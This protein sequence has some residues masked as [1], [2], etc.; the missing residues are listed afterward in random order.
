MAGEARE[1]T[2]TRARRCRD[3]RGVPALARRVF[4][5]R[6]HGALWWAVLGLLSAAGTKSCGSSG[7]FGSPDKPVMPV[8]IGTPPVPP[9]SRGIT[10]SVS[11]ELN[12]GDNGGR[13]AVGGGPRAT[14]LRKDG[15]EGF[16]IVG[17]KIIGNGNPLHPPRKFKTT[18]G[19]SHGSWRIRHGSWR[20]RAPG[21]EVEGGGR[22]W[23]VEIA[24]DSSSEPPWSRVEGKS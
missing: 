12:T 18:W 19:V 16:K 15:S 4:L 5:G 8:C 20:S 14:L 9:A 21:E 22:L 10:S 3:R 6:R 24:R 17:E 1:D 13:G 23:L 7:G 11:G 2:G